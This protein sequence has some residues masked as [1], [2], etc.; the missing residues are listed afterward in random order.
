MEKRQPDVWYPF[1]IDKWLFGSTRIE[2]EPDERGVWVDLMTLSKKDN[3]YIRANVGVPYLESQLSGLLNIPPELLK[4]TIE[5]CLSKKVNKLRKE[6]DGTLY[7]LS[8]ENYQLSSRHKRRIKDSMGD[9]FEPKYARFVPCP[10]KFNKMA[11]K[12]GL[13]RISRL[14]IAIALE[15]ELKPEEV[16]HH[17]DGNE[18]NDIPENLM[19]F[20]NQ[21]DHLQH[22][23][24]YDIK[25]IW[26]GREL[27]SVAKKDITA[28]IQDAKNRIE[29]NRIEENRIEENRKKGDIQKEF[30]DFWEAYPVKL[31]KEDA[32]EAFKALRKKVDLATIIKAFNGYM[33][34]LKDKRLKENFPQNPMY[35]A[36]FLREERW[37][38][39]LDFQYKPSL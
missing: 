28:A 10:E 19:L 4:R 29:E 18:N 31:K 5:K 26:D 25:P 12:K 9:F 7:V 8:T 33:D 11:T 21:K 23:H 2:L 34:F 17:I 37:K 27:E 35:P 13:V 16:V 3:G 36:T 6:K 24:G 38:D 15:R 30:T 1:F 39:Y 22:Q 32:R 20:A 14:I